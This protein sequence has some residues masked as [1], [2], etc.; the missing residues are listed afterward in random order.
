MERATK[1]DKPGYYGIYDK[2]ALC[3]FILSVF[4]ISTPLF[5][6]PESTF[7]TSYVDDFNC[8]KKNRRHRLVWTHR[9]S[10]FF[11]LFFFFPNTRQWIWRN[12]GKEVTHFSFL[13]PRQ[14]IPSPCHSRHLLYLFCFSWKLVWISFVFLLFFGSCFFLSRGTGS[15]SNPVDQSWTRNKRTKP[16]WDTL[17]SLAVC[18]VCEW[19]ECGS[20]MAF[21]QTM[22]W[23]YA[24]NHHWLAM[25][26]ESSLG[27]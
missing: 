3:T 17:Q 7:T 4:D 10:A 22:I 5:F 2:L 23:Q 26:R 1:N 19:W 9:S 8:P 15:A 16:L 12:R 18:V 13:K 20:V 27:R 24:R 14:K 6:H 11:F 25:R 21:G